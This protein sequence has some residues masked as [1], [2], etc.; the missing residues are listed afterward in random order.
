MLT[1]QNPYAD[2]IA[3]M[4][5]SVNS[6]ENIRNNYEQERLRSG[7]NL[8][9]A[10]EEE[11]LRKMDNR[12][13]I[14]RLLNPYGYQARIAGDTGFIGEIEPQAQLYGGVADREQDAILNQMR[15]ELDPSQFKNMMALMSKEISPATPDGNIPYS[16][17]VMS[18]AREA[19]KN[20]K[21]IN[22]ERKFNTAAGERNEEI[23][24]LGL[25]NEYSGDRSV[26][27]SNALAKHQQLYDWA[28]RNKRADLLPKIETSFAVTMNNIDNYWRTDG[29]NNINPFSG[30]RK[31]SGGK[32]K[33]EKRKAYE[34]TVYNG[35]APTGDTEVIWATE[36]EVNNGRA[37]ALAYDK[38]K[39][40]GRL[41]EGIELRGGRFAGTG[42]S[43]E[44]GIE[45]IAMKDQRE[46]AQAFKDNAGASDEE[47]RQGFG[48][49]AFWSDKKTGVFYVVNN[50]GQ[51]Y[52][53]N[54]NTG[55]ISGVSTDKVPV[56]ARRAWGWDSSNVATQNKSSSDAGAGE[57][58]GGSAK[59]R[60]KAKYNLK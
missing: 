34:F 8:Y 16:E 11:Y 3:A 52:K 4:T 41:I 29:G 15:K 45:E 35:N 18:K 6:L 50:K 25:P 59:D 7:E 30:Y 37:R 57:P 56:A 42:E 49:Q 33:G 44:K 58:K 23:G 40:E 17:S 20:R 26:M 43:A 5:Q 22:S 10:G 51:L 55:R 27:V 13:L 12:G 2:A 32:G 60:L 14:S 19:W 1:V 46:L 38:L 47:I 53:G 36:N 39:K 54:K 28:I 24:S 48:Y 31:G 9:K 21:Q